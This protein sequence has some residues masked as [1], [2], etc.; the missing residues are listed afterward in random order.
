MQKLILFDIDGTLI[1][2]NRVGSKAMIRAMEALIGSSDSMQAI[3][4]AG[5]V[6]W[7]I[8]REALAAHGYSHEEVDARLPELWQRYQME[9]ADI[10]A[11]PEHRHPEPLPGVRALLEA[12]HEQEGVLLGLLTGNIEAGAWMKLRSAGLD[13]FFQFGA[14][15]NDAADRPALPAVALE[16]A[17]RLA[18]AQRFAGK[19]IVIVGDTVYDIQ[20]GEALGVRAIGV[21][22]GP[23]D[24]ETLRAAGADRVFESF[25]PTSAVLAALLDGTMRSN[26]SSAR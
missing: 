20:C 4:M 15:G 17:A 6:D 1:A 11:S 24:A 22:T 26:H 3:S 2:S 14:F 5:K 9:L 7:A 23:T 8:W 19:D 10:L 16:R 12:L 18:P 25:E 13:G 21:A